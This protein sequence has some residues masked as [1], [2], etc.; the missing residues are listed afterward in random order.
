MSTS[1]TRWRSRVTSPS[2]IR[3]CDLCGLLAGVQ[4]MRGSCCVTELILNTNFCVH[5]QG[6]RSN[7][8]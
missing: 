6:D 3:L 8:K 2:R 5:P 7:R 4:E 1:R